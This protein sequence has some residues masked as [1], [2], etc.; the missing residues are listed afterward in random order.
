MDVRVIGG[1]LQ[2]KLLKVVLDRRWLKNARSSCAKKKYRT[3]V[4]KLLNEDIKTKFSEKMEVLYEKCDEQNAWLK[5]K[6]SVLK[7]AEEVCG[8]SKGRPQ[9]G[10]TWWWNQ[11]VQKAISEKRKSFQRWKQLP[12]AENKSCYLSDKKKAKRAVAE[13]MKNEAVK[14]ME[15]IRSDRN[16][17][18][19]RM[20]MMKK[21]ANDL[22][23]NNC[24][25]DENGNIVF[26]E[27]GRKRVWKE[28]MEAI[29]NEENSWDGMVNVEVVEGPMEPF[30]LNEVERALGIMKNGKA[31]GPT[32]IVKEHLAAPPHGKQVI[33]QIANEILNGMAMPHDWRMSTVVPI[34]KKKGSV[35]DCASYRGVKLLEHGMKVVERLLEKRLRR[36]VKVDQMQFGFMPSRST[37]DAIFIL[38]RMQESY[39]EK[40]RKLFICFV[41]LE[42]AFDR[43]PRKVIEWALRKKLVP[44]RLVQTVVLMYKGAK[45]RV[46]VGAGHSE[47]FVGVHQG[48]VLSP[49]LFSIVLDVLSEDGRKGVLYEL[50]CA[51]DLVLMAETMEELE[52]QFIRWKAAFEGKGLKVNLGKTKVMER[53]SGGGVVVLA[54]IDPLGVCGKRAKVN[55]V[56][57]VTC[58]KWIHARCAR[59]KSVSR[60]MNGNF[61]CRV[62]MNGAKVEC[63]NASNGCLGELERVNSYCYLGDNVNGGG[64]SELA[65]TRRIGLDWKAFNSVSSM[66]CGKRHTWNIILQIYRTCVRPVMTYGSETWVVR[67]VEIIF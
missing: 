66:L 10:E 25:K 37:V 64:G 53:S 50:F 61:E 29:M 21:E 34:Y 35:M 24:I 3:K 18:F 32:G 14:E 41:D 15:E 58:K 1:E 59:V 47:E 60:R 20:R 63:K 36:L 62:C 33:L 38:R 52:A 48:S 19:R 49:F 40:N 26:D 12:S 13:A 44:E 17:V 7:A 9:H 28:H 55:C 6:S 56:R 54:K 4:W 42:K 45:T 46:K 51:D 5:Y 39:L 67:S 30:A 22:A 43:V 31:S 16:V 65:V 2:H 57:C 27:D 23:G 11:D 8:T